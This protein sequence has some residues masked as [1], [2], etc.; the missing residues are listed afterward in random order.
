MS[1][2]KFEPAPFVPFKDKE[3]IERCRNIKRE[4][5]TKHSN[6]DFNI[7]LI[8]DEDLAFIWF[9][10]MIARLKNASESGEKFIMI[11]PNI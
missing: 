11:T 2:F 3:V 7:Q 10:D 8:K 9:G 4:D 1:T 6:P 5:I